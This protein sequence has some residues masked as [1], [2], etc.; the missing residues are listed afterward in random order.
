MTDREASR[1]ESE[2]DRSSDSDKL[3][4]LERDRSQAEKDKLRDARRGEGRESKQ[5]ISWASVVIGLLTALG[6]GVILTGILSGVVGAILGTIGG[7]AEGGASAVIGLLITLFIAYIIGG[8]ASGRMASRSGVLHGLLVPVLGL[9]LLILT[10]IVA[11]VAG[12]S[13]I[14]NLGGAALPS[15]PQGEGLGAMLSIGGILALIFT[16]LGSILG[17]AWGAKTGRRRGFVAERR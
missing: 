11:A 16:L 6:A 8:Y 2:R 14:D 10:A 3:E 7:A 12:V 13:L 17:G 9:A 15:I 1:R 5:G 4:R